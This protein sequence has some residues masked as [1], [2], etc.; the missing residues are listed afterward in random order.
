MLK[1]LPSKFIP[2]INAGH[3][4]YISKR[5]EGWEALDFVGVLG[6]LVMEK[7]ASAIWL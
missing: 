2:V 6:P 4:E 1:I 3:E 5:G 7:V